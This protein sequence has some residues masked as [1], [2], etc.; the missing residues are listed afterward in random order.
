MHTKKAIIIGSGVAGLATAIRLTLQGFEVAV[1]EKATQ[2]GGK[3]TA[4]NK[5]GYHFDAG[6]S[7]FTQP[8]NIATLFELAGEKIENYFTYSPV[9][10]ACTYFYANGKTVRAYT[11]KEKF[12]EEL[13]EQLNESRENTKKYMER[14]QAA[15]ENIGTVFTD[16]PLQKKKTWFNKR[17]LKAL[18]T[19][20]Y[21]YL[22]K[23]LNAHNRNSFNSPETVQLFNRFATYNGSNPYKAPAMLSLIPHLEQN[24]GVFYPHGGMVN[25]STALYRLAKDKGVQFFFNT[26]VQRIIHHEGKVRGIVAGDKNIMADVVVS[27]GDVYFTYK[28]L[29]ANDYRS[30]KVLRQ[31]RSSSAVVFYWGMKKEFSQLHLHN[32]FF[33]GDYKKEFDIIFNK[34]SLP[35]DPTVYVNIT[36][37]MEKGQAPAGKENWFVMV[38]AP[39]DTGQDWNAI[40]MQLRGKVI[41]KLS[42]AL[43]ED[44]AQCIE[45]EE[46]LDPV[47]IETQTASYKG[48][49]YGSSSNSKMA[50]FLR[51]ANFSNT[52]KGLYFCG[53]SVHPGGGIPLCLKSA[54][55]VSE[56]VAADSKKI[57][58]H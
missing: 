13:E 49:L 14:S 19:V 53:G 42:A 44:I 16:H 29:L 6:P 25:I 23:T 36:S 20:R 17:I 40:K 8:E 21:P 58:A 43:Q 51:H 7:L 3:L 10:V 52:I 54:K 57:F 2:P 56:L 33:S 1:Y 46:M 27:N 31:E 35:A 9:D 55:I 47:T 45:T 15:Y 12:A 41:E 50:A 30:A 34:K 26:P 5:D 22:F 4:F 24:E 38:N 32:I 28:H 37:K 11:D 18:K 48:A 39:A